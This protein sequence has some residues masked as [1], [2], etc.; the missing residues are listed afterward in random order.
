ML[1]EAAMTTAAADKEAAVKKAVTEA[2]AKRAIE[3]AM[4]KWATA[5]KATE[6]AT[7]KR[8]TE[9]AMGKRVTEEAAMKATA[10]EEVTDKTTDEAAGAVKDSPAPGQAPLVARAKRAAAPPRQP[11]VPT[12]VFGNLGLSSFLA[13]LFFFTVRLHSLITSHFLPSSSPSSTA[14]VIGTAASTAST[15]TADAAVGV[16]PG[17][18]PDS[19]PR[20]PEGV[21]ED[22][23]EESEEELE[24]APES[25][26]EVVRE[27][28]PAEGAMI[29]VRTAAAP[30]P[31]CGARAPLS[32]VP[33]TAVASGATTG[34]GMEVVLGHPTPYASGDISMGEAVSTSHLLGHPT[35]YGASSCVQPYSRG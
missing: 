34:A 14:L 13:T 8:V 29:T 22:V 4:T 35:P 12:E 19:E 2:A 15:A 1:D 33:R 24:V 5:K 10:D 23:T 6:E 27:E 31:S 32:S 7:T 30:P 18:A 20:T 17:L 3:E 26:L 9:G 28:A 25:V 11:N 21:P 16:T